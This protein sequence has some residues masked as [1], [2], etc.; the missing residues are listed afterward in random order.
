MENERRVITH[1]SIDD[2][3]LT[4]THLL[5]LY[6]EIATHPPQVGDAGMPELLQRFCESL[7]DYTAAAH[8]K[9]YQY[10]DEK[11]ERRKSVIDVAEKAFPRISQCTDHILEFNDK[12]DHPELIH[13]SNELASL[14]TDL[15]NLGET[16]ADRIELEDKVIRAMVG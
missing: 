2:L 10:F 11:R 4:R 1:N 15:S 8:F 9:L 14:R 3:V 16:L 13:D 5:S 12:Y 7:I 6:N